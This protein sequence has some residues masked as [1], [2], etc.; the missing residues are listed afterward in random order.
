ME[1]KWLP[2]PEFEGYYEVSNLGRIKSLHA[3]HKLEPGQIKKLSLHTGG[4]LSA[5]LYNGTKK[6]Y[7]RY[8]HRLV[9]IAFIGDPPNEKSQVNH[10]DGIKTNNVVSNLEWV[11][12]SENAKHF[13][14]ELKKGRN[15][16]LLT[17]EQREYIIANYVAGTGS[18]NRGNR[19]QLEDMF[20][21]ADHVI[22]NVVTAS[23]KLEKQYQ[24][25]QE[26]KL[27]K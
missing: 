26:A 14:Y 27:T 4:Y 12:R 7:S 9:A 5:K 6:L 20:G 8:V 21:V 3:Y 10:K 18:K 16:A 1:E 15:R 25:E 2:V 24:A 19:K 23:V 11:S 17:R 22:M 13:I